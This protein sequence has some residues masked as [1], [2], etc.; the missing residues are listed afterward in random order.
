[1]FELIADSINEGSVFLPPLIAILK[2]LPAGADRMG[3][4]IERRMV[5][6]GDLHFVSLVLS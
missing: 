2:A 6:K 3:A 5:Q 4:Y 1:V